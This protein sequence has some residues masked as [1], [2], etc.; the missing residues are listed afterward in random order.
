MNIHDNAPLTVRGREEAV[1]RVSE[2]GQSARAVAKAMQTTD[3]TIRK[4]VARARAG[5]ALID[6]SSRPQQK[7]RFSQLLGHRNRI[8]RRQHQVASIF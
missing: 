4:W 3:T 7:L 6:R 1:R 8:D 5:E 2:L